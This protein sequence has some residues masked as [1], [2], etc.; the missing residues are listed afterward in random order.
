ML[1]F[2]RRTGLLLV[3]FFS[4]SVPSD[5]LSAVRHLFLR[6]FRVTVVLLIPFRPPLRFRLAAPLAMRVQHLLSLMCLMGNRVLSL[7]FLSFGLPSRPYPLRRSIADSCGFIF[8]CSAFVAVE[9][10]VGYALCLL[11][12]VKTS[13]PPS[14]L[15]DF[16]F[17]FFSF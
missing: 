14:R 9:F 12:S 7:F 1:D 4:A 17:G 10:S 16:S 2:S 15:Q 3:T 6:R 11:R 5:L 13:F 8:F